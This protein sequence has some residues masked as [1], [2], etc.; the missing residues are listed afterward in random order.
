[1]DLSPW[2]RT[3]RAGRGGAILIPMDQHAVELRA[4]KPTLDEGKA[5]ARYLDAAAEGF[6]TF[7]LGKQAPHLLAT[8]YLQPNHSY[9]FQN[10]VFAERHGRLVGMVLG[11]TGAQ[12]LRFSDEPLK[13]I[14]GYP[15]LRVALV[16]TLLAP[17]FR[18]LENI[19]DRDYYLLA[20]AIDEEARRQGIGSALIGAA[21]DRG[22][23][24]NAARLSLDVS[25]KNEGARRLYERHGMTVE[26]RWPRRL[27]VMEPLFYR[28]AKPL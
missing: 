5:C 17:L 20:I 25:A 9:S 18:I 8:A 12:R 2:A 21:E 7:M 11:F 3:G 10:V 23:E 13:G 15:A 19:G 22:R 28:M 6:Y 16:K 27:P 24:G 14:P 26:S 4:G 1:M